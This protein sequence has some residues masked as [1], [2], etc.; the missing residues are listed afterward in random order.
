MLNFGFC[1]W[2]HNAGL[3]YFYYLAFRTEI[4]RYSSYRFKNEQYLKW[5]VYD[6]NVIKP[7]A[8]MVTTMVTTTATRINA[9]SQN[10]TIN[11]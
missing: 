7:A 1:L 10:R 5:G 2:E 3:F 11:I 9:I 6:V 4:H 8:A